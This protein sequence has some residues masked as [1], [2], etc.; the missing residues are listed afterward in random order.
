MIPRQYLYLVSCYVMV[1]IGC[2]EYTNINTLIFI[3][4]LE[5]VVATKRRKIS[6]QAPLIIESHPSDYTGYPFIT[7]LQYNKQHLLTV[8]DNS[9]DTAVSA[10]VLDLCGPERVDEES[11]IVVI[12]DWY[13]NR[14]DRYPLSFEF[15]ILNMT[16]AVA[17]IYK[18]FNTDFVT[19][20]IGPL[21]TFQ[22]AAS[23]NIR[24]RKRKDLP[25]NIPIVNK[26][27]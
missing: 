20:V 11:I 26:T 24:R 19:R 22:M 13:Y 23:R 2:V 16:E 3:N 5:I 10:Y 6:H 4:M 25:T 12:A 18:T 21:P 1:F 27:N 8:I 15:S 9:D 17:R 7:L 14:R